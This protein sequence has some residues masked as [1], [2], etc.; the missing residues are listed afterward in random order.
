MRNQQKRRIIEVEKRLGF[1]YVPTKLKA[2]LPVNGEHIKV[3]YEDSEFLLRY[4]ANYNR[5]FGLTDLYRNAEINQ[6]DFLTLQVHDNVLEISKYIDAD[7]QTEEDNVNDTFDISGLSSRAKGNIAEDRVKEYILLY[8][9]GLL[10]VYK[11][12][13]D[14]DGVDLIALQSG[15]FHPVYLQVKSRYN[16]REDGQLIL[17]ITGNTFKAHHSF[18]LVAVSFNKQTLEID[19]KILFIPSEVIDEKA[20]RLSNGNL[21]LVA[22][23]KDGSQN[24]WCPYIVSKAQLAEKIIEIIS[25]MD[26]Y[27]R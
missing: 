9:Q 23:L 16:V 12:V 14:E 20:I 26:R 19:D 1:L 7:D 3:R 27:Y 24:Q 2:I 5:I 22:S 18:Y 21:R 17:T 13:I 25:N 10:N 4:N 15:I 8:S 6:G 11:P